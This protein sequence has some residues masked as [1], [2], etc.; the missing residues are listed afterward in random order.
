MK[1]RRM[2]MLVVVVVVGL[3][4]P[5]SS[6]SPSLSRTSSRPGDCRRDASE[7][8]HGPYL[9]RSYIAAEMICVGCTGAGLIASWRFL[10][11]GEP[12][13]LECA[14]KVQSI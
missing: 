3:F 9:N 13:G 10:F 5:A 2:A 4:S 8:M 6:T 1:E 12:E 11:G 14:V 7:S